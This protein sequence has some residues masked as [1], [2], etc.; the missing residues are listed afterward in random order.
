MLA[1]L[2]FLLFT[3]LVAY[4]A[5]RK[6]RGEDHDDAQ[7]FFLAGRS[8][9]WYI[10]AGSLLLTNLS[11]EQLIGLNGS[12]YRFGFIVIAWEIVAVIALAVMAVVF[13][14]RYWRRGIA[15]V[16]QF[17]ELR[18]DPTTRKIVSGI[19]LLTICVG[20]LPFVLYSGAVA[21]EGL[22]QISDQLGIP[23]TA[24]ITALI[25]AVG[26]AG[27][28]Y[29]L[30][31]GLKAVA[32]S[33]TLNG[34]G[35]LAGG[36]LIPFLGIL[37]LGEGSWGAGWHRLLAHQ[38]PQFETLGAPDSAIPMS[39]LF[40]GM[41]LL[42][43]Y[44]WCMNQTIVQRTFGARSLADGQ[45]GLLATGLLKL[46]G[47]L[48]LVL[49]GVIALEMFGADLAEGDLAYPLLVTAVLPPALIGF[50]G[51]VLFGAILSSYN[52]AL[53]SAATLFGLDIYRG[54]WRPAASDRQ[55]VRAGRWFGAGLA[56]AAMICAPWIAHAPDGLYVLMKQ[57]AAIFNIPL[58][59]VIVMGLVSARHPA[60]S[61]KVALLGGAL[62]YIFV[63]LLGGNRPGGYEVHWLHVAG[64]NFGLLV[65]FMF[66][67]GWLFPRTVPRPDLPTAD[68]AA[69]PWRGTKP[70]ALG[71]V[72][73]T[74]LLYAGLHRFAAG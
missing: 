49:P 71:L 11:T 12:A 25:W 1:L 36:L 46:L 73:L 65:V 2:T 3:G 13:F 74:L 72:V 64:L 57:L 19:F 27:A 32:W 61:A 28:V 20:F 23:P 38:R 30:F 22:F 70:A 63:S 26:L 54:A 56:L 31:G 60:W 8:L 50:F 62:F 67:A 37:A 44:Y 6:T 14:P 4:Y 42:N 17:L 66:V 33:D 24:S 34:I 18:Y 43:M 48:Y 7:V 52:S 10:I 16:P 21:L 55:A 58:L 59:A 39:T 45:Q 9:P 69:Q 5:W 29:A 40:T 35:L 53:H 15:T 68:S 51:A 41:L 47:P